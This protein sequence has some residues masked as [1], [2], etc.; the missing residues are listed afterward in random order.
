MQLASFFSLQLP[1]KARFFLLFSVS[2]LIGGWVTSVWMTGSWITGSWHSVA[3]VL[4]EQSIDLLYHR[5]DQDGQLIDGPAILIRKNLGNT[6]SVSGEYLVDTVS[7]ASI[8]VIATASEYT[9]E[10]TETSVGIDY[11]VGKSILS[12]AY[13]NSTENDFDAESIHLNV[14]QDLFGDLTTLTMGYSQ[15][16]DTIGR[17]NDDFEEEA[18]RRHFRLGLS[19]VI[20]KNMLVNLDVETITDEGFLNNA[21]RQVRFVSDSARGYDY[22]FERYPHTRTSNAFSLRSLYYLPY[23]AS[24]K[25]EYRFFSDTWGIQANQFE[26][27]YLH[28]LFEHWLMEFRYRHYSQSKADFYQDLF[29]FENAQNFLARDKELSTYKNQTF[30]FGIGYEF[31]S[32]LDGYIEKGSVNLLLDY[33]DF[34]YDDFRDVTREGFVA[35]QEP[36]YSFD[37]WVTRLFVRFEY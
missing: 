9:E 13:V 28:P 8:D 37:A 23:R 32:L 26:I 12:F 21:Y 29:P 6:V 19:Q 17:V 4:P 5:Y 34:T 1:A 31:N 14:S 36:L 30:G 3:A 20:T 24:I 35:G 11:L 27:A 2:Y 18:D 15:A 16:W 7:G 10:R 22:Q 25:G 33:I